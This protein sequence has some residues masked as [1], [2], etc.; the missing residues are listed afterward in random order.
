MERFANRILLMTGW[1]RSLLAVLAGALTVLGQ[2]PFGIFAVCFVT[3]PLLVWLLD[4]AIARP[5]RSWIATAW[6]AFATGWWFGFGYFVAGLWWIGNALFAE[7]GDYVWLWPFAVL[8][9]PA[10]LAIFYGLAA[11]LARMMWSDGIG[12]IAALAFGFGVAEWLRS[13]AFTGFP[14]NAIGYAAMPVPM[15]MQSASAVGIVGMNA[16][17]VFVFSLPAVFAQ[18]RWRAGFSA[19][20]LVALLCAHA[21]YGYWRLAGVEA[22]DP[23]APLVRIVQ[24]DIE[25]SEKWDAERRNEIFDTLLALTTEPNATGE[26][27]AIIVWPETSIP[28]ILTESPDAV[29]AIAEALDSDQTLLAGAVRSAETGDGDGGSTYYNS[30]LALN[31]DGVIIDAADK[32][33]LVPFGEYLPFKAIAERLGLKKI[34]DADRGYSAAET[35]R[36]LSLPDGVVV[37]PSI[38][39]EAIF[40]YEMQADGDPATMIVNVTNDAWYGNTP[41]PYQHVHQARLR[42]VEN[43]LPLV[44]AANNGISGI[45]DAYGRQLDALGYGVRGAVEARP[46]APL[47]ETIYR[48]YGWRIFL[49]ILFALAILAAGGRL[50]GRALH[51]RRNP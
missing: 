48:H 41:G 12:R 49:S 47:P 37:L 23:G 28:F 35:R 30:I 9:I 18:G 14:W 17:A 19:G 39:Y 40:P 20:L 1:R 31:A 21:G 24:P 7:A 50:A 2:A 22:P 8:A 51:R 44:R 33:H 5:S 45:F 3:F 32:E 42:A 25:Q 10:F 29:A 15:L 27:P 13:F 36:T 4:G 16:L 38:C 11:V 6:P 46:G 43:G 26:K 34:A